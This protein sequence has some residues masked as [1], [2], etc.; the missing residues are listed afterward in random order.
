MIMFGDKVEE[1]LIRIYHM[2]MVICQVDQI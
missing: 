1:K 2:E